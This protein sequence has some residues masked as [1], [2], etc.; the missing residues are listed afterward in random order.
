ME[1]QYEVEIRCGRWINHPD[2]YHC[3]SNRYVITIPFLFLFITMT[4]RPYS[5]PF[6][7]VVHFS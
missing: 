4:N 2:P 1:V 6:L 5:Y 7:K 3:Y